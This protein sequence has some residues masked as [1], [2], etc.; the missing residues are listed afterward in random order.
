MRLLYDFNYVHTVS[1]ILPVLL[2]PA[3]EGEVIP[4]LY[5]PL[6]KLSCALSTLYII[7][8][9]HVIQQK[10][11]H[12]GSIYT[13]IAFDICKAYSTTLYDGQISQSISGRNWHQTSCARLSQ[14]HLMYSPWYSRYNPNDN[15]HGSLD[16]YQ[17]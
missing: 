2:L 8:R 4:C 10:L 5:I 13:H 12:C 11:F 17:A 3:K 1:E 9:I 6:S 15:G 16:V 7:S 14:Q